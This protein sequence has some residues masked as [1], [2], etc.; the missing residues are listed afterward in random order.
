MT[1][2]RAIQI[3]KTLAPKSA[4]GTRRG[5]PER[6]PEQRLSDESAKRS[7]MAHVVPTAKST[8][9]ILA[10]NTTSIR[11]EEIQS[12]IS[13]P[14]ARPGL[15]AEMASDTTEEGRFWL[16]IDPKMNLE[17]QTPPSDEEARQKFGTMAAAEYIGR[18]CPRFD[19]ETEF[20]WAAPAFYHRPLYFEQVG[21]ERY[22]NGACRP[23]IDPVISTAHFFAT[24]PIL[25]YKIGAEPIC[26][27]VYTLGRGRP[28]N[29]NPACRE[30]LPWSRRG[31]VFQGL[32][33][34][35]FVFLFP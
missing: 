5:K 17:L 11:Q 32:A 34:A 19:L 4:T 20:V 22:G 7:N 1:E 21:L 23:W 27:H 9:M 29:Y 2:N 30:I 14:C 10:R 16:S 26:S 15:D 33:T 25:P 28:G 3:K 35:G 24:V 8:S 31:F 6:A 18:G 12:K 13:N